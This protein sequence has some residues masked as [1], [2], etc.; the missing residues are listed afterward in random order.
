MGRTLVYIY[1]HFHW[2]VG[3]EQ[4]NLLFLV[5]N[6][7]WEASHEKFEDRSDIFSSMKYV[8]LI[9]YWFFEHKI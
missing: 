8:Y 7:K 9:F 2:I 5:L 3:F 1:E 4:L 6:A